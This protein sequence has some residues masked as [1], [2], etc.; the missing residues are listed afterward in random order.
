MLTF[1]NSNPPKLC[2]MNTI[3]RSGLAWRKFSQYKSFRNN[4][5][6]HLVLIFNMVQQLG[7]IVMQFH[8]GC[9]GVPASL[10]ID[11]DNPGV[12]K[13]FCLWE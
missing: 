13:P 5:V 10:M 4:I 8:V 1:F 11:H 7:C 6:S 2:A 9:V 12:A 3:G